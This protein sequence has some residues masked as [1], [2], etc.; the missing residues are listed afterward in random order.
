MLITETTVCMTAKERPVPLEK[1]SVSH[2]AR[3]LKNLLE[4]AGLLK[5]SV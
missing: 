4:T 2:R 1:N 5:Y 3:A